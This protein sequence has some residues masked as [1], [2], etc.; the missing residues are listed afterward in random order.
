[1]Y[2]KH[3]KKIVI[4][5]LGSV[6]ILNIN[7]QININQEISN[8]SAKAFSHFPKIKEAE[9]TIS[10]AEEKA[11]LVA[12]NRQPDVTGDAAIHMSGPRSNCRSTEANFSLLH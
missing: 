5:L 2:T 8:L 6:S 12:L 7:A 4:L 3:M 9:N 10:L 1:M 11:K